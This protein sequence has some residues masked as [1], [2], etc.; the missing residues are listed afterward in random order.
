MVETGIQNAAIEEMV[1]NST[2]PSNPTVSTIVRVYGGQVTYTLAIDRNSIR[3]PGGAW[4]LLLQIL[5]KKTY[6]LRGG[7]TA[8][9]PHHWHFM[10]HTD[11]PVNEQSSKFIIA[12]VYGSGWG[13]DTVSGAPQE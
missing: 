3:G 10:K 1:G 6:Q 12:I 7:L 4:N 5:Q 13:Q 9:I 2:E 8:C 11:D